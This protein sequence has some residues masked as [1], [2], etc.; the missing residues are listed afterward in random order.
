MSKTD[1]SLPYKATLKAAPEPELTAPGLTCIGKR[2]AEIG[3]HLDALSN[4][5]Y[6]SQ[7]RF[8][9]DPIIL[10]TQALLSAYADELTGIG[11]SLEGGAA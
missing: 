9:A 10:G 4:L 6:E 8:G 11:D 1:R 5:L 2:L 7:G 3:A